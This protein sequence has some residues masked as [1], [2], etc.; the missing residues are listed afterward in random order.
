MIHDT[1]LN[2]DLPPN[3]RSIEIVVHFTE[4][5]PISVVY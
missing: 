4:L 3:S 2:E 5:K 1:S